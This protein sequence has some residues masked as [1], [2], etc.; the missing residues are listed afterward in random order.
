MLDQIRLDVAAD[1]LIVSE[2]YQNR[3]EQ[4]WFPDKLGT[5]AIWIPNCI[6]VERHGAENGF[7]WVKIKNITYVSCY[8][9]PNEAIN[10]FRAKIDVLEDKVREIGGG[11]VI[12]GD[13]N[14][15][16]IEWG[17]NT[18]DSRGRYILEMAA[19][20]GLTVVNTGGVST[21]RRPGCAQT[22]PDITFVSDTLITSVNGWRVIEDYT[23]SDHQY[24]TFTVGRGLEQT[25]R[26]D[27]KMV[28]WNVARL[29][30]D[31]L[32]AIVESGEAR[33]RLEDGSPDRIAKAT[34]KL[35][36][37]A[38]D[39]SMPKRK[40]PPKRKCVYWWSKEIAT[41]RSRCLRLKRS[42]TRARSRGRA[43]DQE[44]EEYKLA[45]R[46]LKLEIK[47]SK[48]IKWEDLKREVDTDPWGLGYKVVLRKLGSQ[49][50]CPKMEEMQ[51]WYIVNSLFPTLAEE[52]R[53]PC[54]TQPREEEIPAFTIEE[55]QQAARSLRNKK[56]PGP[57]GVPME[58]LKVITRSHPDVLLNMYNQCLNKGVFPAVWKRQRLV[59]ISKG[60]GN[61]NSPSAYRPLC[62][63]DAAGKL[64][65]RLLKP[66]LA[67]AIEAAGG[68]SEQQH[69][70][71]RGRSTIGAIAEVVKA[72]QS[73]QQRNHYSRRIVLL[74]TLDVR[75]AFNSARWG[76][77]LSALATNFH[78][79][80]YLFRMINSYLQDRELT[81]ETLEGVQ[82]KEI[83]GGAAQGSILGPDLWNI[84]YDGI[85]RMEIPEDTLLVGYADDVAAVIIA[86][87]MQDAQR[88][89]NQIMRRV[90]RWLHDH[91][92][93]L[94]TEKTELVLL[95]RR[96]I[97]TDFLFQVETEQIRSQPSVTYLG[98][99]LDTKL[100][101]WEQ[102]RHTTE[103]ATKVTLALSRLMSN[104]GGP[105]SGKRKL[106]MSVTNSILL[107]G[108]EIWADSLKIGK[109]RKQMAAV[110]RCGALR[111][112]SAYR[113]VSEPAA[114]VLAG[115]IP[116][117]LLAQERKLVY[118]TKANL[119]KT[120]ARTAAR[121]Q[122]F[123]LWQERWQLESR[124]RWTAKL[125]GNLKEWVNRR[126]GELNYFMTQFFTG[127]GYFGK[128]LHTMEKLEN[129]VCI[130]GDS[131]VDDA[132]HTFFH[133]EKWKEKRQD[134]E[135][136]I[137]NVTADNIVSKML[138]NKG[139]WDNVASYIEN[140]LRLKK[141]E[142][143]NR[144]RIT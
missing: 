73:A 111:I 22:I 126:H 95:T 110:Q 79:P 142:M 57:D 28:G 91:G 42:Y 139:N 44:H 52:N 9:T 37:Q 99:R 104:I 94:A 136:K 131:T 81:F 18:T 117:D 76:S 3:D 19:R 14:A 121:E 51:M 89:L 137:G 106:L 30:E 13:F 41:L 48:R 29:C 10:S 113:T 31:N 88:K 50:S 6:T 72:F 86:R 141:L 84:A 98:V 8:F 59:L 127:H 21:F 138:N 12:A 69:G 124:G 58:V 116:I 60:K 23:G 134:L 140:I 112:T 103:K 125:I 65:E 75:N 122:A 53:P 118:H 26:H 54:P 143:D 11:L 105:S 25:I 144:Q 77:I 130:Y 135:R 15:K 24:I 100:T 107:Y 46:T 2:Q 128:Y 63:L 115:V 109:Y 133:C 87:D 47:R 7:I 120:E 93:N 102:I 64:L 40:N 80:D 78:I 4:K 49:S 16:A 96:Q 32:I 97:P 108:A 33:L 27:R 67:A 82:C 45:R 17:M 5:A 83:T 55:L 132:Y 101:F 114:L 129:S 119:G 35:V 90:S 61:P 71:R 38:C 1:L 85:L 92:L 74:A 56:A 123:Q 39:A 43:V 66:R 34:M 20:T 70:F 36:Q 62:M 68:L